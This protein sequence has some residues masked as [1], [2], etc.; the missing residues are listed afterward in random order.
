MPGFNI[1]GSSPRQKSY[2]AEPRRRHRW[3]VTFLGPTFAPGDLVYLQKAS[4]P[5]FKYEAPEM[6]HD[7][8]VSYFAGK[9][10]WEAQTW[11][12]YDMEQ[13]IDVSQRMY[14]WV[15]TVTETF[16]DRADETAVAT[17]GE[18]KT[19]AIL[20]MTD[21]RGRASETWTLYG[22]WPM[23]TNWNDLDYTD[24]ELALIE[25]T[26]RYDRAVPTKQQQGAGT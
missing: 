22:T 17:P 21:G 23:E 9:Q 14:Q 13:P 11:T 7:Q 5:Q 6:H 12:F 26:V 3:R 1:G 16:L 2:T 15:A 4:R 18:Y 19:N 24:T 8:E 10:S 25:V 20:E